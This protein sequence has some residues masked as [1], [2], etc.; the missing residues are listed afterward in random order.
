MEDSAYNSLMIGVYVLVF[1]AASTITIFLFTSTVKFADNAYEYGRKTTGDSIVETSGAPKYRTVTGAELLTY[2]YN[3][4]SQDKYGTA[5]PQNYTFV[6]TGSLNLNSI[7][8]IDL[9]RTYIITYQ[10]ANTGQNPIIT[11]TLP[12]IGTPL[13][14]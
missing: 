6:G 10:T 1:I 7:S 8:N 3:Y 2:Y 9:S 5:P 12:A 4:I 11:V 13:T 14:E